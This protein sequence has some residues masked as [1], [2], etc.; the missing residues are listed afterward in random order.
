MRVTIN[1]FAKQ[2]RVRMM[3]SIVNAGQGDTKGLTVESRLLKELMRRGLHHGFR[4]SFI[5]VD[6]KDS[7]AGPRLHPAL[8]VPTFN[9]DMST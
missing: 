8:T 5:K 6:P 7:A 9:G 1:A 4:L 2:D 3:D